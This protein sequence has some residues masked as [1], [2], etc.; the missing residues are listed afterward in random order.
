LIGLALAIGDYDHVRD[1]ADGRVR[2]EGLDVTVLR[3]PPEDIFAR[4]AH[5]MEWEACELS[6]ALYTTLVAA[7]E[8]PPAAI[9]VFPSRV[10]RHG[11]FYARQDG[12][13][14][15]EQLDGA[16]VGVPEWAQT[17]CV[18]AR[19][20]LAEHHGV[21]LDA[22][23]WVQGGVN[24]PG[25]KEKAAL[26]LPEGIS[27][28]VEPERTLNEMLLAGDLDAVISARPPL[29]L[30]TGELRTLLTD[31]RAAEARYWDATGIF[32]IMHVVVLEP[33]FHRRHPWAAASLYGGLDE[34]RARSVERL[35]DVT[36]SHAPLPWIADLA[37]E[38]AARFDGPLWAY[39]IEP[40]R[41]TIEAF[42]RHASDQGLTATRL[43]PAELFPAAPAAVLV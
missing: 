20:I 27:L 41:A 13:T 2:A 7:G 19:G 8:D 30:A 37:R 3:L 14:A 25:R 22:V 35:V 6:F 34:A 31:P 12:P 9:P 42:A 29:G 11:A 43:S 28:R 33:D 40:N 23:E 26:E 15:L 32:P 10:F 18:W 24:L 1:L 16:K 4:F 5:G 36:A 38:A 17:A 39:G 21:A